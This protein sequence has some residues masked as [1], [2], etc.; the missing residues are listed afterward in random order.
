MLIVTSRGLVGAV[1]LAAL[2]FAPLFSYLSRYGQDLRTRSEWS[3]ATWLMIWGVIVFVL[4]LLL[5]LAVLYIRAPKEERNS[6]T[7]E[8]TNFSEPIWASFGT[9][10]LNTVLGTFNFRGI[11]SRSVFCGWWIFLLVILPINS[12]VFA[13]PLPLGVIWLFFLLSTIS[14]AV[15]RLRDTGHS[16]WWAGSFL[17][18]FLIPWNIFWLLQPR[19]AATQVAGRAN[20]T[21]HK[22]ANDALGESFLYYRGKGSFAQFFVISLVTL[23]LFP[24]VAGLLFLTLEFLTDPMGRVIWLGVATAYLGQVGFC[25]LLLF[26]TLHRIG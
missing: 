25:F 13:E 3:F 5:R 18:G 8:G 17:S 24:I 10:F 26:R 9:A 21:A 15:R 6:K 16:G 23:C 1:A 20:S 12:M 14:L 22:T 4:F 2:T 7:L 19:S 11:A